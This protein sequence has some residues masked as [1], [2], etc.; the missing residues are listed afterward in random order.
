MEYEILNINVATSAMR[1]WCEE[2]IRNDIRIIKDPQ[3]TNTADLIKSEKV[4][5]RAKFVL[6]LPYWVV[7][8]GYIVLKK[9]TGENKYTY[10]LNKAVN[11]LKTK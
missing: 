9:L 2:E 8:C 6:K 10:L 3:P 7:N 5:G 1:D 11:P 4:E